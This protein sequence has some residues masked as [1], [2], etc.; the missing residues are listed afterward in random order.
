MSLRAP[1]R[2]GRATAPLGLR[3]LARLLVDAAAGRPHDAPDEL[4]AEDLGRV[5]AAGVLHRVT[6]AM[7]RSLAAADA[8]DPWLAGLGAARHAQTLRHLRAVEDLKVTGAA[9]DAAG[10][11]WA[12]AKGPVLASV[13]WPSPDMR[14]Y[15]DLDLFVDAARFEEAIRVVLSTGGEQ[16]DRNWPE[17]RRSMRAEIAMTARHGTHL[18]LHWHV[19]V[20]ERLRRQ[21]P[22]DMAGMLR[23]ARPVT[24][25]PGVTMP[26][27]DP[28]DTVH[29]VAFH[30]AQDGANR[31]MW[32]A[33]VRYAVQDPG[34]D[35]DELAR[36]AAAAR[37]TVPVALVLDRAVRTVGL[38]LPHGT[39]FDRARRGAWGSLARRRD[40]D[41]PFP[42]LPGDDR[43]G[44]NV[45]GAARP[46]TAA[47]AAC[48]L[49]Y[50]LRARRVGRQHRARGTDG[51]PERPLQRDV[52]DVTARAEY[53]ARLAPGPGG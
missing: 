5:L 8:P 3:P 20:P 12:V 49:A 4:F 41:H 30:A 50:T 11:P 15:Y 48:L 47:S 38:E 14:E 52:A 46:G 23:R 25:A 2:A 35:W 31:L 53:F 43:L 27:F 17:L 40:R 29:H 36:R 6:P 13:V 45:Y 28:V 44:G 21:F 19:A 37:T 9:L 42:G 16:L 39:S 26:T 24:I 7:A 32:L 10:I 34:F 1:T 51:S 18:D 33:D 22:V